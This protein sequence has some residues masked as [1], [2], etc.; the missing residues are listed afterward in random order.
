MSGTEIEYGKVPRGYLQKF[1]NS[2][3]AL[4]LAV[5]QVYVFDAVT[6]GAPGVNGFVYTARIPATRPAADYSPRV[7]PQ[8]AGAFVPMEAPFILWHESPSWR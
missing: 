4:P 2:G 8:H 1:P 6:T 7:I 3:A 5:G